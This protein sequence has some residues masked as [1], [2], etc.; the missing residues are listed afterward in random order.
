MTHRQ[1]KVPSLARHP[2]TLY[3]E[4]P[5][6]SHALEE[7]T[8]DIHSDRDGRPLRCTSSPIEIE[9]LS[10]NACREKLKYA[11]TYVCRGSGLQYGHLA[12]VLVWNTPS[13]M[14]HRSSGDSDGR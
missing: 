7:G 1:V 13:L 12:D 10:I 9:V 6:V 4:T 14:L 11:V 2:R 5:S 3:M 8:T